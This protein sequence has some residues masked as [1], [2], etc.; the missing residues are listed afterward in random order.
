VPGSTLLAVN[1]TL[2]SGQLTYQDIESRFGAEAAA[3]VLKG[4]GIRNRRVAP[5]GV[6]GSDLAFQSASELLQTRPELRERIDLLVHCTQSPDYLMPTT[7]CLLQERLKLR[8][9][10]A[11]FDINLGCSQYVYGLAVA[12]SMLASGVARCAL[13]TTGDTMTH[14]IHLRDRAILPIL[15][16]AGSASLLATAGS[17]AAAPGF[18]GFELG[19]DGSGAKHLMIPASGFRQPRSAETAVEVTDADGN[20]RTAENLYMNGAAI[21]HFAITVVPATI[22][23]L[24]AKL[25]LE[26]DD[27]DLVL[28]HQAN[29]YMLDYLHKKLK[30]PP[31]KA[32]C[33]LENVGNTSGSTLPVVL[34][35]AI[36]HGRVKAGA[37][38]LMIAFGVGLSWGATVFRVSSEL[39]QPDAEARSE[40]RS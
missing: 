40:E 12:H 10:C 28:F 18:L 29:Q 2:G 21:F 16:D 8:K 24:L 32:F 31:E 34:T 7:A 37:L 14:T 17:A 23:K 27:L 39:I 6:C 15:G 25:G 9:E 22:Q 20:T 38:V 30:I 4:S 26:L 36:R 33:Y 1:Y 3:K 5:P 19:T 13:V 11:A 35:E